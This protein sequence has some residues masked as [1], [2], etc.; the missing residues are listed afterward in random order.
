[1]LLPYDRRPEISDQTTSASTP[2]ARQAQLVDQFECFFGA[3]RT[4]K[5]ETVGGGVLKV[6]LQFERHLRIGQRCIVI[7]KGI[8]C[9]G[10]KHE[11]F[12]IRLEF[13]SAIEVGYRPFEVARQH[14]QRRPE[15]VKRGK[16]ALQLDEP[17]CT[18]D[19]RFKLLGQRLVVEFPIAVGIGDPQHRVAAGDPPHG[20]PLLAE[21]DAGISAEMYEAESAIARVSP[22]PDRAL[23][24]PPAPFRRGLRFRQLRPLPWGQPIVPLLLDRQRA[25]RDRH[26][27]PGRARG[28]A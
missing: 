5:T 19:M 22:E 20:T 25:V 16:I 13:D 26:V 14:T 27:A 3:A 15:I 6:A 7:A 24:S 4:R 1:M 28:W 2:V 12:G 21:M 9:I 8:V 18:G 17:G 23:E 10:A 11:R